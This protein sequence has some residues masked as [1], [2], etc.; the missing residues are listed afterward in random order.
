M[1]LKANVLG[2]SDSPNGLDAS[3]ALQ[4]QHH[5]GATATIAPI[6]NREKVWPELSKRRLADV[7]DSIYHDRWVLTS[8]QPEDVLPRTLFAAILLSAQALGAG[9]LIGWRVG[10]GEKT[11]GH[12][13]G[14][15]AYE[16]KKINLCDIDFESILTGEDGEENLRVIGVSAL[17]DRYR[18][19]LVLEVGRELERAVRDSKAKLKEKTLKWADLP[20][21][22]KKWLAY[23]NHEQLM[24]PPLGFN[25]RFDNTLTENVVRS[26][27]WAPPS[28]L[29]LRRV[30]LETALLLDTLQ[31][32]KF[33]VDL[34]RLARSLRDFI[35]AKDQNADLIKLSVKDQG[36]FFPDDGIPRPHLTEHLYKMLE[37]G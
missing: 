5:L 26:P 20:S 29:S 28:N 36:D 1:N 34:P 14:K 33:K 11:A 6:L 24:K 27:E 23:N 18:D 2:D 19:T 8:F 22:W 30:D 13:I 3:Q 31:T 32:N 4:W 35:L 37:K 16:L 9:L 17:P 21:L 25:V 12:L 15:Q 7:Q 10:S